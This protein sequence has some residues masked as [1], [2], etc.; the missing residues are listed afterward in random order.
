MNKKVRNIVIIS[1]TIAILLILSLYGLFALSGKKDIQDRES[2]IVTE[3]TGT[4]SKDAS[5]TI[6]TKTEEADKET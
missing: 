1:V 3:K 2:E 5:D 6:A 4:E